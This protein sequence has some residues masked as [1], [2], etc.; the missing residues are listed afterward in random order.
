[1]ELNKIYLMGGVDSFGVPYTRDNKLNLNHLNIVEEYLKQYYEDVILIDM[2]SMHKYNTTS[3]IDEMLENNLDLYQIVQNQKESISLCRKS[4]IF[5]FFKLPQ[6]TENLYI[7]LEKNK[8]IGIRDI[9]INNNT[10]FVYSCGINDFLQMMD[11][12]L[13]KLLSPKNMEESLKDLED[14]ISKIMLKMKKNFELLIDLNPQIEIYVLGVYIPTRVRYIRSMVK[15]AITLFNSCTKELCDNFSNV[16]FI[17]NSNLTIHEMAHVDWH[18]NYY[19][20][21]MMGKNIIE[22][23]EKENKKIKKTI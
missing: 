10:L 8:S 4:G 11:T 6:K 14:T 3:Y 13:Q 15:D 22:I 5:Q 9:I 23:L 16:H 18:P 21:E 7:P 17:D 2:Y 20:Q 1:M 12:N 19:G